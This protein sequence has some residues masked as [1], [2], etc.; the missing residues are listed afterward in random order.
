[1][2]SELRDAIGGALDEGMHPN[3][4]DVAV[5]VPLGRGDGTLHGPSLIFVEDTVE[6]EDEEEEVEEEKG[7][8]RRR[9]TQS[10]AVSNTCGGGKTS[11]SKSRSTTAGKKGKR[12]AE[13]VAQEDPVS[14]PR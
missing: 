3:D 7:T 10:N 13:A 6:M 1:M 5:P 9:G 4:L 8:K 14:A 12:E 2:T 11:S